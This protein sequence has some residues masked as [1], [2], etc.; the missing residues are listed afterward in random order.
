MKSHQDGCLNNGNTIGHANPKVKVHGK[1]H[2]TGVG[3]L[4]IFVLL[5]WY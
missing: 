3:G 2:G 1:A 4:S 5:H